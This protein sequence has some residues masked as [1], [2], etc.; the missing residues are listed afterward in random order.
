MIPYSIHVA[1]LLAV[2]LLFYKLLLQKETYYR[3]NRVVLLTC[4]ALVF[5][6]PLIPVP[7]QFSFRAGAP[8]KRIQLP[9]PGNEEDTY[10]EPIVNSLI[11]REAEPS[12]T[13]IKPQE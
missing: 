13:P 9:A 3:L 5:V 10:Q 1:I 6:L 7:Q 12:Q 11:S 4:L 8:A 2:C